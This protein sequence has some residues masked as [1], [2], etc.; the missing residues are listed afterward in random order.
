[1]SGNI[2]ST[3]KEKVTDTNLSDGYSE[4]KS[5]DNKADILYSLNADDVRI[6]QFECFY[7]EFSMQN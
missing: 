5:F 3:A 1:M 6:N 2:V 4:S 7:A